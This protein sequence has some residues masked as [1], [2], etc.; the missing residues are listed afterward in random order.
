MGGTHSV[1]SHM[2]N[3]KGIPCVQTLFRCP[4]FRFA[5]KMKATKEESEKLNERWTDFTSGVKNDFV[6]YTDT[7]LSP[8]YIKVSR[9][10]DK[11]TFDVSTTIDI[12]ED[13]IRK[14]THM[15]ATATAAI[16][17]YYKCPTKSGLSVKEKSSSTNL[18]A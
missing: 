6:Y 4:R 5:F 13:D 10:G 2:K 8:Q 7:N 17:N 15:F 11:F 16:D 18:L 1:G 12:E 3:D 14:L 9:K